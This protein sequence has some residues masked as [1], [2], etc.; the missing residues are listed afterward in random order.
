MTTYIV[1]GVVVGSIYAIASLG[2]V[3]TYTS[4]RIFNF[5]QGAI[6]FFVAVTFYR[7]VVAWG[8]DAHVA[9]VV[10]I[11]VFSPLFGLL[12]WALLFRRLAD[13]PTFVRLVSTIGL[14]V[15]L[16]ALAAILYPNIDAHLRPSMI[17]SPPHSYKILGVPLDSNQLAVVA[18]A[19]IVGVLMTILLRWT[20][21]GLSV[22]AT[23]DSPMMAR[24]SGINTSL[25]TA[26]SWMIGTM[27]AGMAGVL[28]GALRGFTVE[29][30][31]F[32]LLGSF[33][34]MVVARMHSLP[35]AFAGSMLIGLLQELS[36][37]Q[38]FQHFLEHFASPNNVLILGLRPSIPFIVMIVFLI[39]Y[40]GLQEEQF[41][42]DLRALAEPVSRSTTHVG[43]PWWRR[44]LPI[45]LCLVGVLV[46]PEFLN[47][48]WLGVVASGLA[49]AIAFLSYV[50]VTGEGG[51]ISLC[52]ITFAGIAAAVTAQFA[53][54]H[55]I[56]VLI[57]I[58]LGAI[59]VVPI[60]MIVALPSLRMG[61]LYLALA[62]LA[63]TQLVQ[64]T[65]FQ[66]PR[67]SNFGQ[68]VKVPRPAGLGTDRSFYYLLVLCFVVVALGV[69]NLKRSTTGLN[70]AA[71]RSSE[72]AAATLG[73]NIVWSKFVAFG[74]SAFV[75][76][77]GGGLYASY[78][79]AANMTQ[80]DAL[81]GVIWL[82]VTVTWGVRSITGALL[83]GLSFTVI[84]QLFTD[85][86]SG[87]WLNVPALL[88][89]LGAIALAREPRGI[90]YD[91]G[92]RH[93]ERRERREKREKEAGRRVE[94]PEPIPEPAAMPSSAS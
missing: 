3:L 15:A 76:G 43:I 22:R 14:S 26:G 20:Q 29:Q 91:V 41:V 45:A 79:G 55:G 65:Y 80:F 32:L 86:L 47:G 53:T 31:T 11:F 16:P 90:V 94:R 5:A 77:I 87:R 60:G 84:P 49:L 81:I 21:F 7:A 6:S 71:M 8:V 85:H 12:L 92:R 18:A 40:R 63:F 88:F 25:V 28:L 56:P 19:V 2:L 24:A 17:W 73:I 68:G 62:T 72:P 9:G 44:L 78:A 23:V 75:A 93:R 61:G 69:R 36:A 4:S 57:A 67:I 35:L 51:L 58:V 70:L 89:G 50:I 52:Q 33:A 46:A 13:T 39:A 59:I 64:N 83:A 54:N 1:A 66:V 74:L 27:L 82:A 48:V 34:A 38:Q 42:V 37:S 10:T 30:F